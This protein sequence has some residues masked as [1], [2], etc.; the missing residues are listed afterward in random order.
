VHS[1]IKALSSSVIREAI[2]Q[3]FIVACT[4]HDYFSV[5]PNGGFFDYQIGNPC[6]E[7]ALSV[8]CILRNCDSRSYPQKLWR[9]AR[10]MVQKSIGGVPGD[11]RHFI[12]VSAFSERIL[13][14]YLPSTATID[15]V[16]NPIE[17]V[18]DEAAD[19]SNNDAFVYVGR[20][21]AEKGVSTFAQAAARA[22]VRAVFVGDGPAAEQI[23]SANSDAQITGW[24]PREQV[25]GHIRCGRA[26]IMP[27]LLY[28]TQGLTVAEAAAQGVPAIVS[29]RC[30][31]TE[32]VANG[33][34][35]LWFSGGNS[36]DLELKMAEMGK[37]GVASK[38]GRNAYDAF[39]DDPAT[40]TQHVDALE[41]LFGKYISQRL[42]NRRTAT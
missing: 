24:L 8:G 16:R 30:A 13:R 15:R 4:L 36:Q 7:T 25:L 33:R 5:C 42:L 1:W 38:L 3:N 17:V 32:A 26:L 39:W 22:R 31:A 19:V 21:S 10:Q 14:E 18:Q 27:S 29:D 20:L 34:T 23:R 12:S 35:G 41:Q 9:V 6:G 40:L 37:P 2:D 28:E 11:I